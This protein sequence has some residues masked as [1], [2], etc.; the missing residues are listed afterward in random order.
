MIKKLLIVQYGGDFKEAYQKIRS[1]APEFYANQRYSIEAVVRLK[2]YVG[3]VT[4]LC[5]HS[6]GAYSEILEPGVRAIGVGA[7]EADG[8]PVTI[9][10]TIATLENYQPDYVVL[11]T[12]ATAILRW[13]RKKKIP[14]SLILADSFN[15]SSLG[16]RIRYLQLAWECNHSNVRWIGNHG[17][18]ACLSLKK[19]GINAAKIVPWDWPVSVDPSR[20]PPKRLQI[21]GN[22]RLL[23]VGAISEDKGVTDCIEAVAHLRKLG[24]EV[25]LDICGKGNVEECREFAQRYGVADAVNFCGLLPNTEVISRMAGADVVIVPS[26]KSYPEG[27]PKTI[28]EALCSRSPLIVSDHPI[29]ARVLKNRANAMVF[30]SGSAI[31]LAQSVMELLG[32]PAL[33]A[34]LSENAMATWRSLQISMKWGKLL[35]NIVLGTQDAQSQVSSSRLDSGQYNLAE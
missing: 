20:F 15:G 14:A 35:E 24:Q 12:P 17:V 13:L 3:E 11:R 7:T 22:P 21:I 4:T 10:K 30:Q 34:H 9:E 31:S 27:F 5:C 18:G 33:Y 1:G 23:Y 25:A 32:D 19:I 16:D 8:Y 28:N 26:R 6:E 2:E 29:F